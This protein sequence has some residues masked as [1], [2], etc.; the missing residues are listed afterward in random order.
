[1]V[2][3]T[4]LSNLMLEATGKRPA[5]AEYLA[6][7]PGWKEYESD[8]LNE[9]NTKESTKLGEPKGGKIE[10]EDNILY[11]YTFHE[12]I[13]KFQIIHTN[14]RGELEGLRD[15]LKEDLK[16][17]ETQ[18]QEEVADEVRLE[19]PGNRGYS[20]NSK[21]SPN[22][23]D[24]MFEE[25]KDVQ[26]QDEGRGRS[27]IGGADAEGMRTLL[28][29]TSGNGDAFVETKKVNDEEWGEFQEAQH[30]PE[31]EIAL[32]NMESECKKD[33]EASSLKESDTATLSKDEVVKEADNAGEVIKEEIIKEPS[34]PAEEPIL[35]KEEVLKDSIIISPIKEDLAAIAKE[36]EPTI[37]TKTELQLQDKEET[38]KAEITEVKSDTPEQTKEEV[39]KAEP[40]P[41]KEETT[42]EAE[43][44][45]SVPSK[46]EI[47]KAVESIKNR[48]E[49]VHIAKEPAAEVS[50]EP[51]AE[52]AKEP[53]AEVA[54]EPA[55][56][57]AKEPAAE[58]A[59]EPAVEVA[60]EPAA[61]VAKNDIA[62]TE[63]LQPVCKSNEA[64]VLTKE[65]EVV[66]PAKVAG[67]N[68]NG[69]K[70]AVQGNVSL[71][72]TPEEKQPPKVQSTEMIAKL[73]NE[74]ASNNYWRSEMPSSSCDIEKLDLDYS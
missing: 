10:I 29:E 51:A 30:K 53:A 28:D 15:D 39:T 64:A 13:F 56:E 9:T 43:P 26:Q 31:Q 8:K 54:K 62:I 61:E 21:K 4:K 16:E 55:A 69:T 70:E 33:L 27:S 23:N 37:V 48:Q 60:K 52:V 11:D 38:T 35:N 24:G 74:Y 49:E 73:I 46:E 7:V 3:V 47:A 66:V 32:P 20:R 41:L 50:K 72:I 42:K 12:I 67:K 68:E 45:Q 19:L 58:V 18:Q 17:P 57:V 36:T 71:Q 14:H 2:F 65:A 44:Q 25:A 59:K 5:V 22:K 34:P 63:V 1:M 40:Q 6:A